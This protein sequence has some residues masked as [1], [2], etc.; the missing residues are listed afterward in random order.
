MKRTR[1]RPPGAAKPTTDALLVWR[2]RT[3]RD[4][5]GLTVRQA[6]TEIRKEAG[7]GPT[8]DQLERRYK[9]VSTAYPDTLTEYVPVA[10]RGRLMSQLWGSGTKTRGGPGAAMLL[11]K[12]IR[13]PSKY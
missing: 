12:P 7:R 13:K 1:G 5:R 3:A 10:P 11:A 9:R 4:S 2:V 6:C 8:T